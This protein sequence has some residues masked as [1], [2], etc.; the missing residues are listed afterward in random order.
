MDTENTL[1]QET[2]KWLRK[3]EK[4]TKGIEP[5][6]KVDPANVRNSIDNIH[7]YIKDCKYF[8]EKEDL[9]RAFEAVVYAW[10]IYETCKRLGVINSS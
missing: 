6:G 4:E 7:A 8:L 5:S 9:V 1:R 3:L 2:N 10:G